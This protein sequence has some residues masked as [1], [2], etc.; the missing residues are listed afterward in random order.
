MS[1]D[2][3]V[4]NVSLACDDNYAEYAGVVI[5]SVLQNSDKEDKLAFYILDG[6]ISEEHKA[7]INDLKTI[8][9][10]NIDF[11]KIDA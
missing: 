3:Q 10:C 2:N 7:Q 11:I 4:I 5:A 1:L 9:N 8:K 6:G